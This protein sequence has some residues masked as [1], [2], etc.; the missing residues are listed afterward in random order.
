[1]G[2]M[3]YAWKT[4]TQEVEAAAVRVQDQPMLRSETLSQRTKG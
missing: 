2:V 4:S 3:T 1:M